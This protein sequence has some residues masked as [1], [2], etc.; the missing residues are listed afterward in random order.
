MT[1]KT[2]KSVLI[3][4]VEI[5]TPWN[6]HLP[7]PQIPRTAAFVVFISQG[8]SSFSLN[9]PISAYTIQ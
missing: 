1:L 3:S 8:E 5:S 9:Q 2:W 7:P 4:S 6:P